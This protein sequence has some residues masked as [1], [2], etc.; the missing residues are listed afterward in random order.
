MSEINEEIVR[1]LRTSVK[2]VAQLRETN[3]RLS[4]AAREPIAI[5][6]TGCRYAGG[7]SSP[8]DLWD[9]V[10][11]GRDVVG[12][13]P[14]DRG[15]D[16]DTLYDPD[17]DVQG[18]CY[19]TRG[20]FLHDANRFDP[21]F[22]GMSPREAVTTDPQQRL[23]LEVT[24]EALERARIAPDTLGGSPTG[25]FVGAAYQ[26]FGEGWRTAPDGLQGHLVTGMSM[27]V[28]SGRVAYSLGLA[29]PAVTVDTACSSSLVAVYLA[30]QS[31]RQGDC[32]L[33]LAGGTAVISEPIGLV[34]FARQRGLSRSGR[35]C[36][37]GADA[38]GMVLGEG[39]GVIL[40]ERLSDARRLGHPVLGVFTGTAINQDG[41]SNGLAAPSGPAQQAVIDA[42]LTRAGLGYEDV[43]VVETHGTGTRL[44]DPIEAD[45]LLGTYGSGRRTP[46]FI[47]SVKTNIGHAQAAS[48]IAGI[49]K[50]TESLRHGEL[51]R[52][53]H[54]ERALAVHR[55]GLRRRRGPPEGTPLADQR[56]PPPGSGVVLRP[57]RHERPPDHRGT[58]ADHRGTA[59]GRRG[60]AVRDGHRHGRLRRRNAVAVRPDRPDSRGTHR[61]RRPPARARRG[62]PR[63]RPRPIAWS[64]ATTRARFDTR[65]VVLART[66]DELLPR[67]A[68][69]RRGDPGRRRAARHRP[70]GRP[71]RPRASPARAPSGPGWR[72]TCSRRARR[73][74]SACTS[75]TPRCSL[76]P[77]G[78]C[79]PSFAGTTT[80]GWTAST[81]S[82]PSSGR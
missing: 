39:V 15:W 5:V 30:V 70:A 11:Q 23:F 67:A 24:W 16:L 8:E 34:G 37:F 41:A 6:A 63:R 22:F 54:A 49:I 52:S 46:L 10:A 3:E 55:L 43:D 12:P 36:A 62:R 78:A 45:A 25:V 71:A 21:A 38:D 7:I 35:C 42:A 60:A 82:S 57:E 76:T 59:A 19:T 1:A 28:L 17:P 66:R 40:L 72:P 13:L 69:P 26:G 31:L 61:G 48:G 80:A 58:A 77:G 73:S 33:A 18:T 51:P 14:T 56:P 75:A 79:S 20:G 64:L 2:E 50:V 65:A 81:S 9:V 29:G 27:S 44:G 47:G 53:L 74:P 4:A 32:S 68:R